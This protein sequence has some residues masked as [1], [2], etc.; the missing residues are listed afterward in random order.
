MIDGSNQLEFTLQELA[1]AVSGK[2]HGQI[3]EPISKVATIQEATSNCITFLANR[4]YYRYLSDTSA[5]AVIL[6]EKDLENCPVAAITVEN[7]YL[8]YAKIASLLN[9]PPE[10]C[11]GVHQKACVDEHAQVHN[12]VTVAANVVIGAGVRIGQGCFIGPGCVIE[13]NVTIGK[14]TR[15][16]ANVT[17]CHDV[18]IGS[19]VLLHPGV[20]IGADGFGIANDEGCWIKVPQLGSVLIGNDV[21][22]GANTTVDRGALKDTVI[23]QGVKL[24]NQIQVAHNVSIGAH[25]AIAGCTGIAGSTRI[26]KHC[27]IGG[28]VNIVGHLEI[29]DNVQITVASTVL[30][31]ISEPGL[32]SSGVPLQKNN[33]WHRNYSR[34]RRLD[35]MAKKIRRLEKLIDK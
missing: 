23:E 11:P 12:T 14:N 6:S 26:G 2:I 18:S 3:H 7:P 31:N 27:A 4:S 19:A 8:A 9:P 21:E 16:I 30:Q 5:A 20:V 22:I 32:Y 35:E 29:V 28:A 10:A 17:L 15:L 33:D 13:N 34:F 25:T 1:D 24:D